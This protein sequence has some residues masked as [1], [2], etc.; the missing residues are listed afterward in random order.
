MN[1]HVVKNRKNLSL[2]LALG[3]FLPTTLK[4]TD[5]LPAKEVIGVFT[6]TKD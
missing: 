6:E 3:R 2:L 5:H 4:R 1:Q